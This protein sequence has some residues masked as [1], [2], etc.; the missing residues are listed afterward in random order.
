MKLIVGKRQLRENLED[1]VYRFDKTSKELNELLTWFY[2]YTG[3]THYPSRRGL[4]AER[5]MNNAYEVEQL[6]VHMDKAPAPCTGV[7]LSIG[8]M[9]NIEQVR[10]WCTEGRRMIEVIKGDRSDKDK[11]L[12]LVYRKFEEAAR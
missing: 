8:D 12:E 11:Y 2:E 1:L 3:K 7:E 6:L 5:F 9:H 4:T 10:T